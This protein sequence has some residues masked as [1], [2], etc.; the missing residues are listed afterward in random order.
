MTCWVH[1]TLALPA[2]L[3]LPNIPP[4][5]YL[6]F[7]FWKPTSSSEPLHC[8]L[9]C[10]W[11]LEWLLAPSYLSLRFYFKF[12]LLRSFLSR[13]PY[14]KELPPLPLLHCLSHHS[15]SF[16]VG[17]SPLLQMHCTVAELNPLECR[18][19]VSR[20]S[21]ARRSFPASKIVPCMWKVLNK[22]FVKE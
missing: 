9:L 13:P 15:A 3:M 4:S 11:S 1:H 12:L 20:S 6:S 17:H 2:S 8:R 7:Y 16:S 22:Y 10:P 14:L 5:P 19:P 21:V 18:F